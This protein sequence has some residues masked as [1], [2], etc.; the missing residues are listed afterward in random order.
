VIS[1]LFGCDGLGLIS[2][3][4]VIYYQNVSSYGAGVLIVL[5]NRTGDVALLIVTAWMINFGSWVFYLLFEIFVR[6][7]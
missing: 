2:Y 6:F 3:L 7:F 1:I 5:S 4:L